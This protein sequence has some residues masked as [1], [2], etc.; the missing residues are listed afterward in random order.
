MRFSRWALPLAFWLIVVPLV[1][2]VIPW[3]ISTLTS[4]HGWAE[5]SSPGIWNWIGLIPVT[6]AIAFL[7]WISV[8]KWWP[9]ERVIQTSSSLFVRG[10]YR[11]TRNPIYIA[12]L[13]IWLGWAIFFGSIGVLVVWLLWCLV[14]IFNLVPREERDLEAAFG[15]SYL[16][17]KNRV[18]RWFGKAN[19]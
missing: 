6:V 12:Y 17:Y 14:A 7:L 4:R 13:G 3:A 15:E 5:G 2:G 10:P 1:H 8:R 11:F 16:Q 18:P 9:A 19:L